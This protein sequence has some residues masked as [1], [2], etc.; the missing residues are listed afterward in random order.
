MHGIEAS[1]VAPFLP[2]VGLRREDYPARSGRIS[3]PMAWVYG[4][5]VQLHG[6][7]RLKLRGLTRCCTK[8]RPLTCRTNR[9]MVTHL[10]SK[11]SDIAEFL[12]DFFA[13]I[14][15][16]PY[17]RVAGR[18]GRP[19]LFVVCRIGPASGPYWRRTHLDTA[20]VAFDDA[21]WSDA[22]S[23]PYFSWPAKGRR[24]KTIVCP[25]CLPYADTRRRV[26]ATGR[27]TRK[28]VPLP[29]A[30]ST[31]IPPP[32]PLTMPFVVCRIGRRK[33]PLFQLA[34]QRQTTKNDRLPHL[35]RP[36]R[37]PAVGS[38]RLVG[39][40]ESWCLFR[41]PNLPRYRRRGL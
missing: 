29:G 20:A 18:W 37:I 28:V 9:Q 39:T 3:D 33:R 11:L 10:Q 4:T 15:V 23:G 5:S 27:N 40:P 31:S 41:A 13:G 1:S 7:G 30:E 8:R 14:S 17:L 16:L 6:F 35:P 2:A 38:G 25:T 19:S 32:W 36:T 22:A 26:R 24:Q 21:L 12:N 34:R